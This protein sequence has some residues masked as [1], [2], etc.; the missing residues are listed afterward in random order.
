LEQNSITEFGVMAQLT[1][2]ETWWTEILVSFEMHHDALIA[3][4]L[5]TN[6]ETGPVYTAPVTRWQFI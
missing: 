3:A 6:K 1:G 4:H 5:D 2:F